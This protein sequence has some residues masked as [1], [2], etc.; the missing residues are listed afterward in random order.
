MRKLLLLISVTAIAACEPSGP[1]GSSAPV[2]VVAA[3]VSYDGSNAAQARQR[4][5]HGKRLSYV[6]GCTG[7]HG[8]DL[9]GRNV[10]EKDPNMGDWWA[11]NVTLHIASYSD[12]ELE[13]LIRHGE[14]RD[15]RIFYFMPA[16]SLQYVSDADLEALVAYLRTLPPT[17]KQTPPV[18]K[19]P[20]F[21]ELEEKGEFAPSREMIRRFQAEQ[22]VNLGEQH[23]LGRYI[24]MTVCSECH[25]SKLQG[26]EGFSPSLDTA[27][28]YEPKELTHLL[29]TGEGKVRKDLGLMSATARH[30]F[31]RLTQRERDAVVQY[32]IA[33]ANEP[34]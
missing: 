7:C 29:T 27:G 15:G 6:L 3:A 17:G 23:R 19:G 28:A 25:N 2:P 9:Q 33:R 4:L 34:Q 31:S 22:P 18:K 20:L 10:T 32:L 12:T 1:D 14:P 8:D 16:E 26:F 30:R 5:E 13:R 21:V 11:P 24:A